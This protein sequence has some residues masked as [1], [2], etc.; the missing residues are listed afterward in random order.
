MIYVDE[1][2][3]APAARVGHHGDRQTDGQDR[4]TISEVGVVVLAT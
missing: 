3:W 1:F 4:D 2:R